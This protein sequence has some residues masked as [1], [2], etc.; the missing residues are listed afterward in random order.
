LSGFGPNVRITAVLHRN[1][2]TGEHEA[3]IYVRM[4]ISANIARGY[5]VTVTQTGEC[6]IVRWNGSVNSFDLLLGPITTNVSVLDGAVWEVT[7]QGVN[8]AVKCDG[9]TV[10]AA[11]DMSGFSGT[12]WSDGNPGMG[13]WYHNASDAKSNYGWSSYIA[14][15]I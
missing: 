10:V 12:Y 6:Y 11:T 4:A 2:P 14:V 9:A 15:E 13:F 8:L 5:E 1:G 3:E 7:M